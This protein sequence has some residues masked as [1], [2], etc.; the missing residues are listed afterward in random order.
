MTIYYENDTITN[1][2][3]WQNEKT[4]DFRQTLILHSDLYTETLSNFDTANP[5]DSLDTF[6][7][8]FS[9]LLFKDAFNHLGKTQTHD[10]NHN[11]SFRPNKPNEWYNNDCKSANNDC[12]SAKYDFA[13]ATR[14][15]K[16]NKSHENKLNF[17]LL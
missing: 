3:L 2:L 15:Y 9:D 11:S 5:S 8:S 7:D 14:S 1:K 13:N 12:K 17:V 6:A 10:N 4:E 16:Q